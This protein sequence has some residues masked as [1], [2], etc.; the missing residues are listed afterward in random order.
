MVLDV[1]D[2]ISDSVLFVRSL[3]R[4][5][6]TDPLVLTRP[7]DEK[8]ILTAYPSRTVTYPIITILDSGENQA[9]LSGQRSQTSFN[10]MQI[11]IRAWARNEK[12]KAQLATQIFNALRT[13]QTTTTTG[14]IDFGLYDFTFMSRVPVDEAGSKG[15]KSNVL[16]FSY[17]M[18]LN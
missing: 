7:S 6:I 10:N 3:L 11:E 15:I 16:T 2:Y 13:N 12:E 14:S 9:E 4:T 1:D 8:F 18:E 17:N 5:N